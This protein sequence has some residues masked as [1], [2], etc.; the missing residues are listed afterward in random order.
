MPL[1]SRRSKER[2]RLDRVE[3]KMQ[4]MLQHD[5]HEFELAMSALLGEVE[6]RSVNAELRSTDQQ[7]N[8]LEREIRRDLLVH[9]SV[10]GGIDT[11]TVLVYM[12]VVKDIERVG[13]YAKNLLDIAIW[14]RVPAARRGAFAR[15][16]HP[17][18]RDARYLRRA[19]VGA[20]AR[21]GRRA[22]GGPRPRAPLPQAGRRP[23]DERPFGGDHAAGQARLLRR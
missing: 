13:D 4:Q 22:A 17:G 14:R 1:K 16:A 2:E 18:E 8:R 19:R 7:V 21:G 10:F 23:P 11:P 9:T 12:S 5:R 20:G 15:A 3:D 6:P